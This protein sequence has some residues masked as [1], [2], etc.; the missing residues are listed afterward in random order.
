MQ[1]MAPLA[2]HHVSDLE[3]ERMKLAEIS[4]KLEDC[5]NSIQSVN[6]S[7]ALVESHH[8]LPALEPI[9]LGI[10]AQ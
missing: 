2:K 8:L 10:R 9:R 6:L 4:K 1:V 3:I 7:L 5:R